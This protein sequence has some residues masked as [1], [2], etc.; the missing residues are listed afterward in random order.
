MYTASSVVNSIR[1]SKKCTHE[2]LD[3][4]K[5]PRDR[6]TVKPAYCSLGNAH[7][8]RQEI[9]VFD[10]ETNGLIKIV[11]YF[12]ISPSNNDG[13]ISKEDSQL[14]ELLNRKI[15]NETSLKSTKVV[16]K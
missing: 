3:Y 1:A 15:I 13:F 14:K 8:C 9:N 6:C 10:D 5:C 16:F 11:F 12:T 2:Y 7:I 4:V